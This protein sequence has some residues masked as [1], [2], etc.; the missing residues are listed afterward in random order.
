M[1]VLEHELRAAEPTNLYN[2]VESPVLECVGCTLDYTESISRPSHFATESELREIA[3]NSGFT[4][5]EIH[6]FLSDPDHFLNREVPGTSIPYWE[7]P[8]IA[9][10]FLMPHGITMSS[11]RS[12][13]TSGQRQFAVPSNRRPREGT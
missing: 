2:E 13:T 6:A 4:L 5:G 1:T 7:L 9:H 8:T 3:F 12:L 11:G 10:S